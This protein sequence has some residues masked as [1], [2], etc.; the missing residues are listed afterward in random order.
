MRHSEARALA[1]VSIPVA[2]FS[3]RGKPS[4]ESVGDHEDREGVEGSSQG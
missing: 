2:G 3:E 1:I 4:E